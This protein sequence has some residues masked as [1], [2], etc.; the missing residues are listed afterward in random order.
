MIVLIKTHGRPDKQL[1][2]HTLRD[3]GYTGDIFLILDNEDCLSEYNRFIDDK[4]DPNMFCHIF[5]KHTLVNEVDSGTNHP[6]RDVNLYAWVACERFAKR[7]GDEFFIMADDDITGFRY[8]YLEDGHLKSLKITQN[9]DVIF[10]EV[11]NYM[12][13]ADIAAMSTGIPQMYFNSDLNSN[14]HKWRV[15]YTFVFRN[16]RHKM[17]WV[18]EYEEDIIT[19]INSANEGKYMSVLP[20][21]QRDTVTMG[22]NAGGMHDSYINSFRN[23]Q[24]GHIWHPSCEQ[25]KYYK[26]K[27]MCYI[28]RDNAFPKLISSSFKK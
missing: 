4:H 13:T 10:D 3:A 8:R 14:L 21:I 9:L 5:D 28:D 17:N 7:H 22:S 25:I 20:V 24:Y 1:T 11:E 15:P 12:L 26:N 23:A 18:S 19:A 2:Y 6:K 27:W 16:A